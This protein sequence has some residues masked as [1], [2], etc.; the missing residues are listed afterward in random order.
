MAAFWAVMVTFVAFISE[1]SYIAAA[2]RIAAV[3][4]IKSRLATLFVA[5][6][7]SIVQLA[8]TQYQQQGDPC[9]FARDTYV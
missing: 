1:Y 4:E 2:R 3:E 5:G 9:F 7:C 6:A 8:V